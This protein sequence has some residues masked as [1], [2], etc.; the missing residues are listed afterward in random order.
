MYVP[1]RP[2]SH[3]PCDLM[4][5]LMM[6]MCVCVCVQMTRDFVSSVLMTFLPTRRDGEMD[7]TTVF[8]WRGDGADGD[9][10]VLQAVR[11]GFL[12]FGGGEM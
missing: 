6:V 10:C 2:A 3:Q 8:R 11:G 12:L 1:R 4:L 9:H 5:M 7:E